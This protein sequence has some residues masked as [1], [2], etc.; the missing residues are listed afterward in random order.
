MDLL[1]DFIDF[2]LPTWCTVYFFVFSQALLVLC[3]LM[4]LFAVSKKKIGV[5]MVSKENPKIIS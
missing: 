5:I 1:V 4:N 2:L 3:F